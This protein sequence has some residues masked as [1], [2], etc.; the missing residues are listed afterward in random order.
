MG[1]DIAVG[2]TQRFGVPM[3]FGGPSAAYMSCKDA[4]KRAMPGRIVG[5]S[6]DSRGTQGI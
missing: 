1:A 5:V 3:G 4:Y 2:S 6:R